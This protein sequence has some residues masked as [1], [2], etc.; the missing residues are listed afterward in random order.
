MSTDRYVVLVWDPQRRLGDGFVTAP[1]ADVGKAAKQAAT[2]RWAAGLLDLDVTTVILPV[3]SGV[4]AKEMVV[5]A[6]GGTP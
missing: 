4:G 2:I 6:T 1:T 5:R 3:L